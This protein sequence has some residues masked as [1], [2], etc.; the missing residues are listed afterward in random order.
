MKPLIHTRIEPLEERRLLSVSALYYSI[1]GAGNNLANPAWGGSNT[2]LIRKA[3]TAYGNITSSMA[4]ADRP[5]PRALSN[6]LGTQLVDPEPNDRNMTDMIYAWGQFIDHDMDLTPAGG[7]SAGI[8]VPA[9]DTVF[10]PGST[11]PFS[12]AQFDPAI[13]SRKARQQPNTVTS[14]LDGSMIYGSDPTRAMALRTLSGGQLKTSA[15]DLLPFNTGNLP[16]EIHIPGTDP[17]TL[18]LAGDV[19]VN[20][21]SELASLQ[22]LFVREHNY[23]AR[24]F[25]RSNPT[26]SDQMI[27]DHAR[28]RVIAEIQ[29][30][31]YNEFLP[32]MLGSKAVTKYKGYNSRTNPSVSAE[33]STAAFRVGHTFVNGNIDFFNNDGSE[34][35]DPVDFNASA[36]NPAVLEGGTG[37]VG[38]GVDQIL[39]YLVADNAQEG[40]NQIED[41]LRNQLFAVGNPSAGG[42][43]LYSLDVQRGRDLGLPDYNSV[44]A[45]Y[46]LPRIKSFSQITRDKTVQAE[47]RQMYG[48]HVHSKGVVWDNVDDIDLFVGGL[49]ED[50][51]AGGSVG[52]LFTRIIADQFQRTRDGDRLFYQRIY[53]GDDLKTIQQT[54][55]SDI[56][57]RNTTMTNL[58]KNAFIFST[59][60]I[61]GT[62]FHDANRDGIRQTNEQGVAGRSVLLLDSSNNVVDDVLTASDG[63]YHFDG[64]DQNST[65]S[66]F[67]YTPR[68]HATTP[69]L[70]LVTLVDNSGAGEFGVDFGER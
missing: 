11:I 26:W 3:G 67:T 16:D 65:F 70:K 53:S 9:D 64:L 13:S 48:T 41:A 32:A 69:S 31:T 55:L 33:F 36:D 34:S 8:T 43:D 49:S 51:V 54:T 47:L 37:F 1:K 46:G 62:V 10:T 28:Q 61:T 12:R 5:N 52:T 38:S 25:A 45:A 68:K 35:H 21:N 29:S 56:I 44:R 60:S 63:S 23:W 59:G 14:F 7:D 6:A 18:F 17:T 42:S 50:H 39:K 4:G 2:D 30:I 57:A 15:G 24:R 40:D 27:Y 19:R 66:V 22:V 58:Q 20:E